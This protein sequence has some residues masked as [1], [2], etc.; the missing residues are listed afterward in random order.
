MSLNIVIVR[1]SFK[2]RS[3]FPSF[4]ASVIIILSLFQVKGRLAKT[5]DTSLE[6]YAELRAERARH[7]HLAQ[8]V[9]VFPHNLPH[10]NTSHEEWRI[11]AT[12][13]AAR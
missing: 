11:F 7:G 6:R 3:I 4:I 12:N 5:V 8:L 1:F 13:L 9:V 10:V 2:K